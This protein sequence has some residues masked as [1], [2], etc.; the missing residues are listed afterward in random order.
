M[1]G[2]VLSAVLT[3][4]TSSG[5]TGNNHYSMAPATAG[6]Q[7]AAVLRKHAGKGLE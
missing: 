3:Y 5:E 7:L 2:P 1:E 6:W 4:L